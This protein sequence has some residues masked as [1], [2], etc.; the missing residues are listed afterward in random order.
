MNL[1][2]SINLLFHYII[3]TFFSTY[4]TEVL[5]ESNS[6]KIKNDFVDSSHV[7]KW[8]IT[9]NFNGFAAASSFENNPNITDSATLSNTYANYRNYYN[10]PRFGFSA[11]GSISFS[12][13]K[14]LTIEL[15]FQYAEFTSLEKPQGYPN[16]S[17]DSLAPSDPFPLN[18]SSINEGQVF[19]SNFKMLQIP[20]LFTFNWNRGKS[21]IHISAGP[22]FSYT[23]SFKG[24]VVSHSYASLQFST[25]ADSSEIQRFGI[26]IQVKVLYSY[27]ILPNFSL[28]AGPSFQYR[29]NSLYDEMYLIRQHPYFIGLETGVRVHF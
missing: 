19:A 5:L 27:Q 13:I 20:L 8:V 3:L 17:V 2:I 16:N 23:S 29:F 21:G 11:G 10:T 7:K 28:Y 25:N 4:N 15:G 1:L 9:A 26:G 14:Y 6:K 18:V 24:Y 22:T 12:P